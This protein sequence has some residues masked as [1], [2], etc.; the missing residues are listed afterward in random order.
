MKLLA[1]AFALI[2]ALS[3]VATTAQDNGKK[4][5]LLYLTE[6]QGFRHGSV[7]RKS[8]DD[9]APSEVA[10]VELG[11]ES[12][13]FDAECTQDIKTITAEKLKG[14]DVLMFYTTGDKLVTPETWTAIDAWLKSGKAFVGVHS[15]TDTMKGFKP[16]YE[17]IN[18]SFDGHPWNAGETVTIANHEPAHPANKG[19]GEEFQIKDEIYQYRNYDPK[20]VRV[21]YS[22]NMAKCKTKQPYHV[23]VAWVREHGQG[24]LFYTNLGHNESTW[25]NPMFKQHL[26][27]GIR[28][29]AGL[30]TGPAAPNPE[31]SYREQARAF[32]VV[33]GG[34]KVEA[35]AAKAEKLPA[36][37]LEKLYEK[38]DQHRRAGKDADR[39]NALRDEIL[40]A[41]E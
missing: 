37:T 4:L 40:K 36:A 16:Y 41:I 39:R 17:F 1:R 15:A 20:A 22:L 33:A 6:S 10:V 28:W 8:A 9:L 3:P 30:E 27:A 13:Q 31:L 19:L 11:K 5:K 18:G 2:V 26:L 21:L 12:G 7:K 23:P 25:T 38:I 34:E 29:A 14:V 35:L 32:C 24:R